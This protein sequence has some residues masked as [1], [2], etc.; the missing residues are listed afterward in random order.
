MTAGEPCKAVRGRIWRS[1]IGYD[2][3]KTKCRED[4]KILPRRVVVGVTR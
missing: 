4:R 2:F 1:E 3:R